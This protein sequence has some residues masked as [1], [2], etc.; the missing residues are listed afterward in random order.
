[1]RRLDDIE[2]FMY[3]AGIDMHLNRYNGLH[4]KVVEIENL[5]GI[6]Y[7][8]CPVCVVS[9]E[10]DNC[11]NCFIQPEPIGNG[12]CDIFLKLSLRTDKIQWLKR[13][14]EKVKDYINDLKM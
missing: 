6:D 8:D 11:G 14:S 12:K 9:V 13:E 2:K 7:G 10:D 5:L 3:V 1:M 4:H